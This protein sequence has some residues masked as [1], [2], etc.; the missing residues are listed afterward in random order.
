MF[1]GLVQ[2]LL[3]GYLGNYIKNIHK[4]QL[5]IGPWNGEVKLHDLD[6]NL[7]AFDNLQLPFSLKQGR[8]GTLSIKIPWKK[9]GW[10]PIEISLHN[11]FVCACQRDE[12]EWS[13][14]SVERREHATKKA[15]LHAAEMAKPFISGGKTWQSFIPHIAAKILDGIQVSITDVHFL[16][17]SKQSDA[18]PFVFGL[19]F[20]SLKLERNA[21]RSYSA[22]LRG[23]EVNKN[24]KISRLEI[25][26][27]SSRGTNTDNLIDPHFFYTSKVESS[28]FDIL[29]PCDVTVSIVVN[30]SGQ[31]DGG[32]PQ[33]SISV[34]LT[35]LSLRLNESQM[36]QILTLWDYHGTCHL[37]E[38]YG[39]FRPWCSTL[40][41]KPVGWQKMWWRYAQESV[42]SDIRKRLRKTSWRYFGWRITQ[43]RNY[44][45]LYKKKLM[46]IRQAQPVDKDVLGELEQMEKESDIDDIL[47]YRSVAEREAQ[48]YLGSVVGKNNCN[49]ASGGQQIEE[50][51]SAGTRGWINWLSL[52]ML[53]AGGVDES[54]QFS[55]VVS[56]EIVKDIYEV[57]QFHPMSSLEG[58]ALTK[59]G[60]F[61]CS[62]KFNI[63]RIDAT[64]LSKSYNKETIKITLDEAN[65][66]FK[67]WEESMNILLL[68]DLVEM[69]DVCTGSVILLTQRG[70]AGGKFLTL[71]VD[72]SMVNQEPQSSIK[73]VFE[74]F[75]VTYGSEFLLNIL[76]ICRVWESFQFHSERVLSSLNG[77]ESDNARLV[78]KVEYIFLNRTKV[79]LDAKISKVVL[80]VPWRHG[81]SDFFMVMELG[82][83]LLKSSKEENL[84]EPV[85]RDQHSLPSTSFSDTPLG[86]QLQDLYDNFEIGF[87]SFEVNVMLPDC[88]K[89]IS[90]LDSCSGSLTLR[91]CIIPDE[92]MLEQ[93]K[94]H[95]SFSPL[96]V[97]FSQSIYGALVGMTT[98]LDVPQSKSEAVISGPNALAAPTFSISVDLKCASLHVDFA[99]DSGHISAL[100]LVLGEVYILT[101]CEENMDSWFCVKTLEVST[102]TSA[103][104]T[105]SQMLCSSRT[106]C[107]K[108]SVHQA[109]IDVGIDTSSGG[110]RMSNAAGDRCLILHCQAQRSVAAGCQEYNIYLNDLDFHIYPHII[111]LLLGFFDQLSSY[112]T[113]PSTP[114]CMN[115]MNFNSPVKNETTKSWLKE[116]KFG[117]SNFFEDGST[118]SEG[119]L[120]DHF[121]FVTIQNSGSLGSLEPSVLR[122]LPE[123]SQHIIGRD[124][125]TIGS[126]QS[127]FEKS[128]RMSIV[129][130]MKPAFQIDWDSYVADLHV[131]ALH[132]N[133]IEVYFHDASCLL[134]T[135]TLPLCKSFVV[136]D[137]T[138]CLD[139]L[140]SAD[141]LVLSSSWATK[142]FGEFLWGYSETG[143]PPVLNIRFRKEGN[144]T[145]NQKFD[146]CISVQHVC[147]ILPSEFLSILIGYFTM[148]AW[149]PYGY[150]KSITVN[151]SQ[152]EN[153]SNI[154]WKV[155]ILDSRL[156]SPVECNKGQ[157]LNLGLQCL[158]VSFTTVNS[159]EDAL[160]DIPIECLVPQQKVSDSVHLLNIFGRDSGLSFSLLNNEEEVSGKLDQDCT[161]TFPLLSSL[162]VDLWIRIP[163]NTVP[164]GGLP[165]ST[166]VMSKINGCQVIAEDDIFLTGVEAL[167][168]V[169]SD[170]S[171]VGIVSEG[172]KSDVF[173]F[174]HFKNSLSKN[175]FVQPDA[176]GVALQDVRCSVH[177]LSIL[178]YRSRR[179]DSMSSELVAQVEMQLQV[180]ASVRDEVPIC[181]E[182]G[183]SS[184][185]LYSLRSSVI[186]VQCTSDAAIAS[187]F[188]IQFAKSNGD[189]NVISF[190]L[191]SVHIWLHLSDWCNVIEL[192]DCYSKQ[193][194]QTS[195]MNQSSNSTNR[196]ASS[197]LITRSGNLCVS[198][199]YPLLT[200]EN[201][202]IEP[203]DSG[204]TLGIPWDCSSDNLGEA[205]ML[206]GRHC[207]YLT[208][209]L[210]C[211]NCELAFSSGHV[212][213]NCCVEKARGMLDTVKD[214]RVLSLPFFQLFQVN[215]IIKH[216]EH[217][218]Q[219]VSADIRVD[220]VDISVSHQLFYVWHRLGDQS[221]ETGSSEYSSIRINLTLQLRK[222]SVLLTDWTCSCNGPV[223]EILLRNLMLHSDTT[224]SSMQVSL[225]S[226]LLVNYFN[227]QKVVWEPFIETW[228]FLL[229][230][231]RTLTHSSLKAA[232]V[233][234]IHL[235]STAQLNMNITEPAIEVGFRVNE[236]IKR[237]QGL[238][239]S[240]DHLEKQKFF[241]SHTSENLHTRRHAPYTLQNETSLPLLF[242]VYQGRTT[243]NELEILSVKEGDIVYPGSSVPIYTDESPEEQVMRFRPPQSSD[244]LNEKT[245]FGVAHHLISIQLD[246][247]SGP[248]MPISMD[249]VGLRYFEVNFSKAL[250]KEAV[251][252]NTDSV[253]SKNKTEEKREVDLN[254][255]FVVPVVFDVSTLHYRKLVRVYSTVM[256][257]N[258]TSTTL[259][260]QFDTP[261]GVSPKV[262]HQIASG[263]EFPLPLHLAEAGRMRLRPFKSIFPWSEAHAFSNV[264]SHETKLGS[265]RSFVCYPSHPSGDSFRCC[266][267]IQLTTLASA[268]GKVKSS[269]LFMNGASRNSMGNIDQSF[270]ENSRAPSVHYVTLTTP[271]LV[272]NYMPKELSLTIEC[273]GDARTLL[274]PEVGCTSVFHIDSSHDLG[275][276]FHMDGFSNSSSKFPCTESFAAVARLHDNKFSQSETLTFYPDSSKGP[277]YVTVEK[278]MD[279]L[280]G[281]REL[282]IFVPFLLYNCTGLQ[283]TVADLGHEMEGCTMPPCNHLIELDQ[284]IIRKQSPSQLSSKPDLRSTVSNIDNI[285]N[286]SRSQSISLKENANLHSGRISR[287]HSI[288]TNPLTHV[289]EHSGKKD[290]DFEGATPNKENWQDTSILSRDS[291]K[292]EYRSIDIE[293]RKVKACMYFPRST[294]SASEL[295]VR[296]SICLPN[297]IIDDNKRSAWSSPFYLVPASGSTCVVVPRENTAGAFIISVTSSRLSGPFSGRT[298]AITFQ[299][300]YVIS[301]ACSKDLCYKQKGADTV[302]HLGVGQHS[303]LHWADPTRELLV[304]LVFNEPGWLWS[305]SFFPDHLGD[306][307]VKMRN[308]VHGA[309]SMIRVEVQN[310]DVTITDKIVMGI[311]NGNS[312]TVLIRLSDDESGFMPYRIDNFS[313]ERL[314]IYQERCKT[315][316][317]T[318]HSYMSCPYTW[319]EPCYPR[320]LVVEVLGERILGSYTLDDITDRT[321]V[322]LPS[323]SEKPAR[324][325][326]LSIHSDGVVKVLSIMD[327]SYLAKDLNDSCFSA[328]NEKKRDDQ[329]EE[330]FVD[331]CERMSVHLPFIGVS[332][333]NSYPQELLF[334]SAID[335]RID[336]VQNVQQQK[337]SFQISS[338]Q[339]DNQLHN[340]AY[341]VLLSLDHDY[342]G[343]ITGQMKTKDDNIK[344]KNEAV[345]GFSSEKSVQPQFSLS[346]V[347]WRNKEISF[348]S[349]EYIILRLAAL[350]FELEEEIILCLFDFVK[351]VIP[352]MQSGA[353]QCS[354][355]TS[356][357]VA[358]DT[359][360]FS[361]FSVR[362]PHYASVNFHRGQSFPL[363]VSKYLENCRSNPILPSV[364]PIEDL[365]EQVYFVERRQ[366]KICVDIF[367]LDPIKLTLSFSSAPWMHRNKGPTSSE[368]PRPISGT[369]FQRGLM[370][371]ADVEGAPVHL[372]KLTISHHLG[373]PESFNEILIRH[374]TPQLLHEMYKI[375]GSASVIGNPM[376]F[377]KN[378]GLGIKDLLSIPSTGVLKSPSG[379]FSGMA[380][381]SSSL[382]Y[383]TVYAVSNTATQFSKSVHKSI[384]AFTFDEQ[385]L[386]T[387]ERQWTHSK[388]VL[389]DFLEGLTGFLQSP[390]RGAEK[391]G[392]PGFL[393]GVALGTA[394]LVARPV[395]S[396]LQVTG[397]TAQSIRNRSSLHRGSH[398]R[399]RVRP[400]RPLSRES[401]LQPY[402]EEEAMG[403]LIL[404][405]TGGGHH[406]D[407]NLIRCK[408]LGERGKF[409]ILTDKFVL[410][411]SGGEEYV[412]EF[413]INLNN[414]I[415]VGR[416]KEQVNIVGINSETPALKRRMR[417]WAPPLAVFEMKT[418]ELERE[419]EAENILQVLVWAVKQRKQQQGYGV[420]VVRRINFNSL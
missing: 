188:G 99:D 280:C 383:N 1:E 123:R 243:Q 88:D 185:A 47:A 330:I 39:R 26:C 169:I 180:S 118:T 126:L 214:Q 116:Q 210:R 285:W 294:S 390:I 144:K 326:F 148:P 201:I 133:G 352:K 197:D 395:A 413:E 190:D 59:N 240:S 81:K 412:I 258:T 354:D 160:R 172:F 284:H 212:K 8:V 158:Y 27:D 50:G 155:E 166:C 163:C 265:F 321:P 202:F 329:K 206:K 303:H 74:P 69:D 87:S 62:I 368:Y 360:C 80:K 145:S 9:L 401:A 275:L 306:T 256:L 157:S 292:G 276:V 24:M 262:L 356:I 335:T 246:G 222:L 393:S 278:I 254:S 375:F 203:S 228:S 200:D 124:R 10:D 272:R 161:E 3:L 378:L 20:S 389:N 252:T 28:E 19:R 323:T 173:Q 297:Y 358:S 100:I 347:K 143:L 41:S 137:D 364:L 6:L 388:G 114:S 281:A 208:L 84:L 117:F 120:F 43:R 90:I 349:F 239:G 159:K 112:G 407:E 386:S 293:S 187:V 270:R 404:S 121:P 264:L 136:I 379:I 414:V 345:L 283:I 98:C 266:L 304:S 64:L 410:V 229:N 32:V 230:L 406:A 91:L 108:D 165:A 238:T 40:S 35:T 23:A 125:K 366:N 342:A 52:G 308:Y 33:Y 138:G 312:G 152:S 196:E 409:V 313:N 135:V 204:S 92:S 213:L 60:I 113:T 355:S 261:F 4:E 109:D 38:K 29:E 34:D 227:I 78:S 56:D 53:G 111:G 18:V 237:V 271:L 219:R 48:D 30:R 300:R 12:H 89:A 301:N 205:A 2:N 336:V 225:A 231:N 79:V 223:L 44:V 317:T 400:P 343:N 307:Q 21:I 107:T 25:Y 15:K 58:C 156:I 82:S 184:L 327:S 341:P 220:S 171:T 295:M 391:H 385:A 134:A 241:G 122:G 142:D 416:D 340:T 381:G 247:T 382:F 167:V 392:L 316:E 31:L 182:V 399:L 150:E 77:F 418:V 363:S 302:F 348:V 14:D 279:A 93:L 195:F 376:G 373:T 242:Q 353:S 244:R 17:T 269:S 374:Y 365:W 183:F 128:S 96:S 149:S 37:R 186:L 5:K 216:D 221:P 177:S 287:R 291:K 320:C 411:A 236:L 357:H 11:V 127:S 164:S 403:V 71:E 181:L 103:G 310:A 370:A 211:R 417:R 251:E 72:T 299:P 233:T 102:C 305:G 396:I 380:H 65:M 298:R 277:I 332:V 259:E 215:V 119:I 76:D 263:Q 296:L 250:E 359:D 333:I 402:S 192:L 104:E 131:I 419:E 54:N 338:L 106:L 290:L 377:A 274:I 110:C 70:L 209:T 174:L 273:S 194:T 170:F 344:M 235:T 324:E 362:A 311:P 334:A 415:Y 55:G 162:D 248:S 369:S 253:N 331:Y 193:L 224:A 207:Q 371:L 101:A 218:K 420:H 232:L 319:D 322:Y 86:F 328:I 42:L 46:F 73:A 288:N 315:F 176:S 68:V 139:V 168:N 249:I 408:T 140:C 397:K 75:E 175:N 255:G 129:Q 57:T 132:L 325:L 45:N 16:Y 217:Q 367:I 346:A 350:R 372:E 66:V 97:H 189:T 22:I 267:S 61:L 49:V 141:G 257:L 260:L 286:S 83:L 394:G 245:S 268:T 146:I 95:F 179:G 130:N 199:H 309:L 198:L 384:V 13:C 405:N 85:S 7:E 63:H 36:H 178:L 226:D 282:C 318:V 314:R 115:S 151:E 147:C 94:V 234:D 337:F 105:T 339:V 191:P 398:C 153:N 289:V 67:L 51:S 154:T 361:D 387:M 351:K